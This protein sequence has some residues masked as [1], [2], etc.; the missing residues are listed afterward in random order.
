MAARF[1]ALRDELDPA[2]TFG[3]PWHARVLGP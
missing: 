2:R 1:V 3:G